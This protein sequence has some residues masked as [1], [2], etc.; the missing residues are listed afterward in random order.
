MPKS[1]RGRCPPII[2]V[3]AHPQGR[4]PPTPD[5]SCPPKSARHSA[6]K[7]AETTNLRLV[8][9]REQRQS[10]ELGPQVFSPFPLKQCSWR[11]LRSGHLSLWSGVLSSPWVDSTCPPSS[12]L[13]AGSLLSAPPLSFTPSG[14]FHHTRA[15]WATSS[16]TQ[17]TCKQ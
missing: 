1:D 15:L 14:T 9:G 17:G 8:P 5:F 4:A 13:G 3:N 10:R 6:E 2:S 16:L 12:S 11:P 7:Q